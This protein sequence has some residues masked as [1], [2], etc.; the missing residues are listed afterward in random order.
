MDN[1]EEMDRFLE[2]VNLPWLN[3]E[4]IEIMNNP[5]NKHWNQNSDQKSP[6][7]QKPRVIWLQSVILTT[8]REELMPIFLKLFPKIA[9]EGTLPNLFYETTVTLI[10]KPGKDN[11]KKENYRQ[12]LLMNIDAKIPNKILANIIWQHAKKLIH[13][14]QVRFIPGMQGFFNIH[15]SINVIH[16]TSKLI[17]CNM[18][19]T[20]LTKITIWSS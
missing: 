7:K 1:L 6:K 11:T 17:Q 4:E 16:H 19:Y 13:H 20:I 15:K 12:I 2:K 3:Q 18:W 8:F 5:I 14:D 10:P 9:E